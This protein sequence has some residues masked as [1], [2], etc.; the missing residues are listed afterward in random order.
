MTPKQ[1][2]KNS[3]KTEKMTKEEC[4]EVGRVIKPHGL[5]GEVQV[6]LDVD[7]PEEYEDME[8]V[9]LAIKGELLPYFIERIKITT[10]VVIVKFDGIDNSEAA[11]KLKN[12]VLYLP[13]NLLPELEEDGYYFHELVGFEVID[14]EK[15]NIGKVITVYSLPAQNLLAIEHKGKEVLIPMADE[16]LQVV[17]KEKKQIQVNL[18]EGLLEV[19]TE[20]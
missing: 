7:Y 11:L 14:A 4:Y 9:F 18:P 20:E 3:K 16:I 10:N 2:P 8:S 15:G 5:K 12:A 1:L 13:E 6:L 19:Y 17:D